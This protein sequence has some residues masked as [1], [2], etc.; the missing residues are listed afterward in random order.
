MYLT[1]VIFMTCFDGSKPS[2]EN[3]TVAGF[4]VPFDCTRETI[5]T[6]KGVADISLAACVIHNI[7][8]FH[9]NQARAAGY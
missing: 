3:V 2:L 9:A 1:G 8:V 5:F 6:V 7:A 4:T